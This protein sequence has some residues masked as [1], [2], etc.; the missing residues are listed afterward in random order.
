MGKYQDIAINDMMNKIDVLIEITD[1]LIKDVVDLEEVVI[2]LY[3]NESSPHAIDSIK[4]IKEK[5]RL[6]MRL[7]EQDRL[8]EK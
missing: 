5:M 7:I 8:K 3:D 6:L 2:A 4:R 1:C